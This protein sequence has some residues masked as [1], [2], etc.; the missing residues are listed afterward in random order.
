MIKK[1]TS[2]KKESEDRMDAVEKDMYKGKHDTFKKGLIAKI[3]KRKTDN[4]KKINKVRI[5]TKKL[6]WKSGRSLVQKM[7]R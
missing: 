7:T 5:K 6:W 1:G 2:Y 4:L 3:A